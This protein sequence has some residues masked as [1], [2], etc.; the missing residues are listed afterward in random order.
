MRRPLR[1]R[2]AQSR[3]KP[4][5]LLQIGNS[6]MPISTNSR[7]E[8]E[9]FGENMEFFAGGAEG[10]FSPKKEPSADFP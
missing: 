8:A 6:P 10:G 9:Q 4:G 7:N 3:L 1:S 2:R 5:E